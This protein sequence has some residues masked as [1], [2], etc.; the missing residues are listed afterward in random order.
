MLDDTHSFIL[1]IWHE[2][3]DRT[4]QVTA[5]RGF[6]EHVGAGERRYFV[7]LCEV[8]RYICEH[9]PWASEGGALAGDVRSGDPGTLQ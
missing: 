7:D 2:G 4:G 8:G 3:K 5:W 6:I 1:R 9:A